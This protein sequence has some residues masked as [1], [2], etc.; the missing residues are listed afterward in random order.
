MMILLTSLYL[1]VYSN[2][3]THETRY[4]LGTSLLN[5]LLK[6]LLDH[7]DLPKRASQGYNDTLFY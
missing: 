7:F 3:T 4:I 6:G 2:E 5:V 1:L